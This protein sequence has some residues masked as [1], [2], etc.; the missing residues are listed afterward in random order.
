MKNSKFWRSGDD[1]SLRVNSELQH[2]GFIFHAHNSK[3]R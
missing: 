1:A 3:A 2:L